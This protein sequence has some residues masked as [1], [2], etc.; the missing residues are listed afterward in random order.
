M[1]RK[2]APLVL[3]ALCGCATTWSDRYDAA[4]PS[5]R[6]TKELCRADGAS[7]PEFD[8]CMEE[9]LPPSAY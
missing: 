5:H 6:M 9:L 1:W 2:L 8:R 3:A 4:D 7:Q